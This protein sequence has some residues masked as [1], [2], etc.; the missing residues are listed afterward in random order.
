MSTAHEVRD[1]RDVAASPF[2]HFAVPYSG[3]ANVAEE[4]KRP[5]MSGKKSQHWSCL[6][7]VEMKR[8]LKKLFARLGQARLG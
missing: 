8:G 1:I 3:N 7:K 4:S 6:P 2:A 5:A